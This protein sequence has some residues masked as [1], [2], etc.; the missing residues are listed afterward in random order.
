M[1]DAPS[2]GGCGVANRPGKE[3]K[4][5]SLPDFSSLYQAILFVALYFALKHLVFDR[6]LETLEQRHHRTRGGLGEAAKLQEEAA[7]LRADY[8]AQMAEI[9]RQAASAKEEIRRQAEKEEE[10]IIESARREAAKVLAS[11]R[12]KIAE[13]ARAARETLENETKTLSEQIL[14]D[15]LR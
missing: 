10:E 13:E 3:P 2:G 11:M 1:T 8:E 4:R 12:A 7:R 15:V 14:A 9:R 5:V 6:F